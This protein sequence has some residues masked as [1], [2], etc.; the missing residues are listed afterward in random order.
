MKT[1]LLEQNR[2]KNVKQTLILLLSMMTLMFF[3]GW[4][5]GGL[6]GVFF[7]AMISITLLLVNGYHSSLRLLKILKARPLGPGSFPELY[8]I[9]GKITH[10]AGLSHSPKLYCVPSKVM[11]AF[12]IGKEENTAIVVTDSLLRNLNLREVAGI[13]GHEMAHIRNKDLYVMSVASAIVRIVH[14]LSTI[15]QVL[16]LLAL[17][18][19]FSSEVQ[20]ALLLLFLLFFAPTICLML[21]MALS[22]TREYE[23]DRMGVELVGDVYGLVS[24]LDKLDRYHKG[25]ARF[26]L[27]PWKL[28]QPWFLQTHPPPRKRIGR[29]LS[30]SDRSDDWLLRVPWQHRVPRRSMYSSQ[31]IL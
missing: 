12:V 7:A 22:R 24:A 16:V 25:W 11:N 1:D 2:Y 4:S 5:L 18:A 29:L 23:A 6:S 20:I 21:M 30:M 19:L 31:G 13:L 9:I 28:S 15:G 26:F 8:N 17:P 27:P 3:L 10:R 14:F